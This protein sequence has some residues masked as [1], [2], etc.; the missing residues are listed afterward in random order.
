MEIEVLL[1]GPQATLAGAR[2]VRVSLV[3]QQPKSVTVLEALALQLPEL[4]PSLKTSR[5]AVNHAFAAADTPISPSDEVAL[6]GM[7]S[8]G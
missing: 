8:G 6:I 7:V 1:F 5:L 2:S 3:D 4:G